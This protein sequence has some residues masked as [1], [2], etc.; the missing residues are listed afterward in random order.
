MK[1]NNTKTI[2]SVVGVILLVGALFY[3][4]G[5]NKSST[6]ANIAADPHH[7]NAGQ[8]AS[9]ASLG[10]L[11]DKQTPT[12]SFADRDG[13]VYSSDNLRGKNVILFFNEG[14]MCYPACW[15]QIVSL[16]KDERFKNGDM[17]VLSVVVD[18]K[19]DWQQAI[20]KMPELAQATVV[21]DN[22]AAVSNQFGVLSTPSSMHPGSLPGH[23]YVLIDKGGTVRYV[24]DDPNMGI[25]N[26]Q[27]V[28]EITKLK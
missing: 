19:D 10:G 13:S 1:K 6:P 16:S 7:P 23:T 9:L 11:L 3:F 18:S 17:V 20:N 28:A 12:F 22:G 5:R 27:L 26:D 21:F 8:N 15:N 25:R 24:F 14:L 2:V 4:G